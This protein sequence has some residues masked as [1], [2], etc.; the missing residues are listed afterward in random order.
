MGLLIEFWRYN[1]EL[2]DTHISPVYLHKTNYI[3]NFYYFSLA[4]WGAF[5]ILVYYE[6]QWHVKSEWKN[7]E[8]WKA[9][10]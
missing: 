3:I 9:K 7:T 2:D 4:A 10:G 6:I 5:Q 1:L 8:I